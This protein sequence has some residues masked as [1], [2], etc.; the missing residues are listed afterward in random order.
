M[1][2]SIIGNSGS[3]KSTLARQLAHDSSTKILDLDTI[4]WEPNRPTTLRP[5][6]E[7]EVDLLQFCESSS[8]WI[9]E[10]CYANLIK[11]SFSYQPTLIFLD[12][13]PDQCVSNCNKRPWEPHKYASKKEQDKNLAFLID[14]VRDYYSRDDN[15]SHKVHSS[16]F[17]EYVGPKERRTNLLLD[18][19]L[20]A[21]KEPP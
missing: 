18:P 1:R 17:A 11:S 15:L 13:G 14:W 5:H 4:A 10:G 16:L 21:V 7:A 6:S 2:I 3:G 8:S 12:P 19:L 20:A 9:V